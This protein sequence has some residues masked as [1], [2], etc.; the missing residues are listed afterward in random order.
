MPLGWHQ[1][2]VSGSLGRG[3]HHVHLSTQGDGSSRVYQASH[4]ERS[5]V[6]FGGHRFL[7]KVCGAKT[8]VLSPLTSKLAPSR[9]FWT[10]EGELA[11]H[12]ICMH[13]SQACT[14]CIPI[15]ENVYSIITDALGLGIGGVLQVW[16]NDQWE[17]AT[18]YSR[19]TKGAEQRYSATELKALAL[20]ETVR[21][22]SYYLYGK[23]FRVFTDHK[24]LCQLLTS[25]RLNQRLRRIAMK[26]QHLILTIEY[27]P[28]CENGFA[29]ALSREE[30]QRM[31]SLLTEMDASFASG[32][33]GEHPKETPAWETR[34][35]STRAEQ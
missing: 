27:L 26:L 13:I 6:L 23:M 14:L 8:A 10:E 9:V 15:P 20:V 19:Q 35:G 22:F 29:D 32:D 11:F 21:H 28:V 24:P 16:R 3:G 5:P 33:V 17:V 25:D 7:Q 34:E 18:F 1:N 2:G 4:Q 30:P 12:N 31:S